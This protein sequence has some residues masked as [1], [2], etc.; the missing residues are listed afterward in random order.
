MNKEMEKINDDLFE[1]DCQID[2]KKS[3]IY[4]TLNQIECN[5]F[6]NENDLMDLFNINNE[7][8]EIMLKGFDVI[9]KSE[10][11]EYN[12]ICNTNY[13]KYCN[14]IDNIN[15]MEWNNPAN[16]IHKKRYLHFINDNSKNIYSGPFVSLKEC[17]K[18][19]K[20]FVFERIEKHFENS[21]FFYCIEFEYDNENQINNIHDDISND[22]N[23]AFNGLDNFI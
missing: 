3:T 15:N 17:D 6:A 16:K 1:M 5:G 23:Q 12:K 10:I 19:N 22:I 8:K 14:K 18:N 7:I 9:S 2:K 20:E 21:N 11:V 13:E 4:N